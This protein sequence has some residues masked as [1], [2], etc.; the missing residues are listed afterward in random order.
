MI[1]LY[2]NCNDCIEL[3]DV[4]KYKIQK[5]KKD[6]L[7]NNIFLKELKIF[8]EIQNI[9][10]YLKIP[11]EI[12]QKIIKMSVKTQ[13]CYYCNNYVCHYHMKKNNNLHNLC[14]INITLCDSCC[15]YGIV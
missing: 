10:L 8:I 14:K 4:K 5:L 6:I 7:K 1:K 12:S 15:W 9:F 13:K 11:P 3:N 2:T